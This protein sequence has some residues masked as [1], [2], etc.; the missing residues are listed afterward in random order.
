MMVLV[1]IRME[2][3]DIVMSQARFGIG[4]SGLGFVMSQVGMGVSGI[5]WEVVE[6]DLS[7]IGWEVVEMDLSG[8]GIGFEI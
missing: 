7:G 8:I 6:M 5:G 4:L 1:V 3:F 2:L